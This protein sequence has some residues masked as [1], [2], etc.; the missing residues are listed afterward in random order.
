MFNDFKL[1]FFILYLLLNSEYEYGRKG[2]SKSKTEG[3]RR[4]STRNRRVLYDDMDDFVVSG[5]DDSDES[6]TKRKKK[7]KGRSKTYKDDSW[8]SDVTSD[9]GYTKKKSSKKTKSVK[10]AANNKPKSK[11]KQKRY[12]EDSDVEFDE[13]TGVNEKNILDEDDAP[14]QKSRRTRG[15]RTKYNL[16][17]DDSSESEQ[18]KAKGPGKQI[19]NCVDST[20]EEYDAKDEDDDEDLSEEDPDEYIEDDD[21]KEKSEDKD[22]SDINNQ[23][24]I[25]NDARTLSQNF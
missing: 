2:K 8:D 23:V 22:V 4:K 10:R 15:K 17:L 7:S 19:E 5:S 18:E 25:A 3:G 24:Q 9:E 14:L 16:I 13:Y 1:R 20:E 11:P 21:S 6:Y 12:S